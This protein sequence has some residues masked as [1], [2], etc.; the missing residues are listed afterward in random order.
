MTH[1]DRLEAAGFL[2]ERMRELLS[3]WVAACYVANRARG[4]RPSRIMLNEAA[5]AA[6]DPAL[7][8]LLEPY[9]PTAPGG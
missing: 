5:R 4:A 6:C 8:L 7:V 2:H 9:D 1:R 3:A